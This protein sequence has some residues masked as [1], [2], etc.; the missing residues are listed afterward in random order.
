MI[1]AIRSYMQVATGIIESTAAKAKDAATA[2]VSQGLETRAEDIG[3]QVSVIAEDLIEQ[4]RT[5]REVMIGIVRTEVDRAVGRMGFVRE[6]ELAAVRKHV[7]RLEQELVARS[8]QAAG[9]ATTAVST[10][11]NAGSAVRDAASKAAAAMPTK[12]ADSGAPSAPAPARPAKQAPAKR[13]PAKQAPA[14][15]AS[16][17]KAPAKKAPVKKAPP[18][19]SPAKTASAHPRDAGQ[20]SGGE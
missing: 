17:K 11:A 16:V 4:G 12:K 8:N 9:I 2:I 13:T 1:D 14:K 3:S 7:Q 10:A 15:K 6:E 20:G 5:N 19:K 18:R